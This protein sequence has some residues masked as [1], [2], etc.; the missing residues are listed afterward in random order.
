MLERRR[1]V[2]LL[3]V[4]PA[5]NRIVELSGSLSAYRE[6]EDRA[7]V[8]NPREAGSGTKVVVARTTLSMA[9]FGAIF[10]DKSP[11]DIDRKSVV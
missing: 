4:F 3:E 2:Y 5:A 10:D 8:R 7:V 6:V 11:G 9:D 1:K